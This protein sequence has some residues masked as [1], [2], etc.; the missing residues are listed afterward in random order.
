M[1][2]YLSYIKGIDSA[3]NEIS[4]FFFV[5]KYSVLTERRVLLGV[6]ELNYLIQPEMLLNNK[7]A[8]FCK[9]NLLSFFVQL[10]TLPVSACLFAPNRIGI[11]I[12][13]RS[14]E[15]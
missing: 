7:L 5:Y 13:T 2:V 11:E 3:N 10:Q 8:L 6:Q 4:L 14:M 9:G 15:I 12:D 1:L